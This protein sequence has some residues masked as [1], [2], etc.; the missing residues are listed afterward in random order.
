MGKLCA[1]TAISGILAQR[2]S[3]PDHTLVARFARLAVR[4]AGCPL[5]FAGGRAH[6]WLDLCSIAEVAMDHD[7]RTQDTEVAGWIQAGLDQYPA[8]RDAALAC[9]E[10]ASRVDPQSGPAWFRM[11]WALAGLGRYAEAIVAYDRALAI[12]PA[13]AD[14]W[15][16]KGQAM[17]A[18]GR[19]GE[20]LAC[21]EAALWVA[22]SSFA[23]AEGRGLALH[24][25]GR[26][27]QAVSSFEKAVEAARDANCR[28]WAWHYKGCSLLRLGRAHD[29][30]TCAD[31]ALSADPEVGAAW[32]TKGNCLRVLR[33]FEGALACYENALKLSDGDHV[34]WYNHALVQEDLG[35][36]L[37]AMRSYKR[38][39]QVAPPDDA[40]AV[41]ARQRLDALIVGFGQGSVDDPGRP[42]L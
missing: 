11:G 31:N 1:L 32:V 15:L 8:D 25:L 3:A 37:D 36:A 23:A 42:G 7:D 19:S 4:A 28:C 30:L 18:L 41:L 16:G 13:N 35:R 34:A 24:A 38:C 10:M 21:F 2:L 27:D 20:A 5:D 14:A 26:F 33:Q 29:A 22:P 39:L 12:G 17:A 40:T 9:F 6:P